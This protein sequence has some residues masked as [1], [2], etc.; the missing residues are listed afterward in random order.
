[1]RAVEVGGREA[2]R[3]VRELSRTRRP[4]A[5]AITQGGT[6][7]RLARDH[8]R[9]AGDG[10]ASCSDRVVAARRARSRRGRAAAAGR[11][12]GA[13]RS[14]PRK[15]NMNSCATLRSSGRRRARSAM[16]RGTPR[17]ARAPPPRR[18]G[19]I[20]RARKEVRALGAPGA[21]S[22]SG[23]AVV[24][25]GAQ[26]DRSIAAAPRAPRR[27]RPTSGRR[28]P[29]SAWRSARHRVAK[30]IFRRYVGADPGPG[31]DGRDEVRRHLGRRRRAD[32]ARGRS[33]SSRRRTRQPR[34]RACCRLAA[35]RPTSSSRWPTRSPTAAPA[36][37]GH[38]ALDRRADLVRAGRDGDQRP[39]PRG[40]LA[41]RL[42]GGDRHRHLA[43]EGADPRRQGRPH[44]AGARRRQD[45][46]R[47]RLP[48]RLDA[49]RRD[50]A[51][52]RRLRH[53]RGRPRG[54]A[55]RRGVRDL[56]RRRR[57]LQRRPADRARA[58]ASCRRLVRG[59]ARDGGL[60]RRRAAAALGRVRAQPRRADPLPIELRRRT[61]YLRA[62][63]RRRWNDHS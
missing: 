26:P 10:C 44:R 27:A 2:R 17:A 56:H 4:P 37:D 53:D 19:G 24:A 23:T 48:G 28:D 35:R 9:L 33:A 36:R 13:V 38:A 5:T 45:R 25:S 22:A 60:R 1:M 41:D 50:D 57:R 40:D 8:A 59:D 7:L 34:G 52:A 61:R 12:A 39:R 49:R 18:G 21:R 16:L 11:R 42:A 46:A 15:P 31:R 6:C 32:Q 62:D 30:A 54:R 55:R 20:S 29:R 3:Q 47:R 14:W 63:E 43:H 51:R 58:R